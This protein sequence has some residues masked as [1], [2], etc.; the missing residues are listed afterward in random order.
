MRDLGQFSPS[1]ISVSTTVLDCNE[2]EITPEMIEAGA[3]ALC[4]FDMREDR[5]D[6][7]VHEIYRA[8]RLL[9]G[10]FPPGIRE[11]FSGKPEGLI[12]PLAEN[13]DNKQALRKKRSADAINAVLQELMM[14]FGSE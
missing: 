6:D 2:I 11:A 12:P 14:P 3:G 4:L 8:M 13:R 1:T 5:P 7:A 10:R 9:E